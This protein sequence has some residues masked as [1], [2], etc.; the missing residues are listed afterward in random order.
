MSYGKV[1]ENL[2]PFHQEGENSAPSF[3]SVSEQQGDR[4]GPCCR[5]CGVAQIKHSPPPNEKQLC[6]GAV[7]GTGSVSRLGKGAPSLA[8]D[9]PP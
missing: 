5:R 7:A 8:G 2:V 1:V 3:L 6:C 9:L 4:M